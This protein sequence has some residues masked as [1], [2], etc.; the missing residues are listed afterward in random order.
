MSYF[1]RW[2]VF[3]G[4]AI[5]RAGNGKE[6]FCLNSPVIAGLFMEHPDVAECDLQ[7]CVGHYIERVERGEPADDRRFGLRHVSPDILTFAA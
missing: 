7:Q 5:L 4:I 1:V 3:C 6:L 2:Q